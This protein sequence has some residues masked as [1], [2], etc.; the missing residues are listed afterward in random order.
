[1][2]AIPV[3]GLTVAYWLHMLATVV[4]IG[5]LAS[6]AVVVLPA[7][8]SALDQSG[9]RALLAQLQSRLQPI[10]WF[11]LIVLGVT[12][13]FQMSSNPS[14]EGLLAITNDW[15]TAILIKHLVIGL[16]MMISGYLTW[17]VLPA[18]RR[19]ALLQAMQNIN[20]ESDLKRLEQREKF[21][22]NI[23]LLLSVAVLALTAW[24]RAAG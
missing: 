3:L 6:M 23:N 16:M 9:Y 8:R 20:N 18:L 5:C 24:A 15:A 13:M 12:G 19:H 10:S 2:A 7:A 14:Y 17:G 4:W 11:C 22:L 1:M 21:L